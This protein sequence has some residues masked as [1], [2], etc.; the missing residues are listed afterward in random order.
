KPVGRT[1]S[2]RTWTTS[3]PASIRLWGSTGR[4]SLR[5]HR[6]AACTSTFKR[7][8]W[9]ARNSSATMRLHRYLNKRL[10]LAVVFAFA[11]PLLA[12][13][14]P[15][16]TVL[17]PAGDFWMGRQ[18][19]WLIDELSMHLRLRLDD[20]PAHLTYLDDFYIDKYETTNDE[21]AKFLDATK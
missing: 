7:L 13:S 12:Q 21:Y 2:S 9:A 3:W 18:H 5:I 20:T 1:N 6:P 10:L 4:R 8:R 17:I 15:A 19:M 16:D 14:P 11:L